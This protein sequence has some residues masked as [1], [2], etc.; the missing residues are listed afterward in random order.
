MLKI[1]VKDFWEEASCGEEL[2]L[3]GF[4]AKDYLEHSEKRYELEPEILDF[5]KFDSFKDLKTL[6]VGVGLGADHQKLAEAGAKLH[7]I[8]LTERAINHT[9]RRFEL[10]GLSSL[11]QVAD[12]EKL[13]FEDNSF[14]AVYS[15]GV[16]HHSPNTTGALQEIFRVLKPG[17]FAKIMIYHKYSIVGFM[18]WLRYGLFRFKPFIPWKELYGTYLESPGTKAYSKKEAISL[19]E[20]FNIISI[21]TPVNHADLLTSDVGQKH[22]GIVLRVAKFLWPRMLIRTFFPMNGLEMLIHCAK[23]SNM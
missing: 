16:I 21:S 23:P 14:D 9:K 13:P 6:E 19:F 10:I 7:G 22:R 8:D 5:A 15:W 2:Y 18:L 11:L 1:A 17:G 4:S 3:S 12:A 20:N